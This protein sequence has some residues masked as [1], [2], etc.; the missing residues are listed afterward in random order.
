MF[1]AKRFG[2]LATR[3]VK[4]GMGVVDRVGP[5]RSKGLEARLRRTSR[6]QH[7]V[8]TVPMDTECDTARN[9]PQETVDA[10]E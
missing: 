3:G 5:R 9:G 4:E 7:A 2:E 6:H 8:L 10:V 1:P